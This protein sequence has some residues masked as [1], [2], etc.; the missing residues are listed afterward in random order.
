MPSW[1]LL[2]P[3]FCNYTQET[4]AEAGEASG[5]K[6]AVSQPPILILTRVALFSCIAYSKSLG[7]ALLKKE[8]SAN[9]N[10]N[11]KLDNPQGS[12]MPVTVVN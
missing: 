5:P 10:E 2:S 6:K 12:K 11:P 9:Q 7:K 1:M 8:S 4:T 3:R